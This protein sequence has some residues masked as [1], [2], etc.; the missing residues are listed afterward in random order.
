MTVFALVDFNDA[1]LNFSVTYAEYD[2]KSMTFDNVTRPEILKCI[3]I[4]SELNVLLVRS[5]AST[6]VVT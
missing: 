5:I 2:Q 6:R 4:I 1:I 3:R